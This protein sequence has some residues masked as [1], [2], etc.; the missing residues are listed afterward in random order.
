MTLEFVANEDL[1]VEFTNSAGPPDIVYPSDIGIADPGITAINST[2][3]KAGG[4]WICKTSL[5]MLFAVAGSPCP[6]TSATHVFI[7]G[8]G[9]LVA[10]AAKVLVDS[11]PPLRDGDTGTCAGTWQPPGGPP[12]PPIVC[13]CT[14]VIAVAGQDKV[15]AQ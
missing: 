6:H 7:A 3:S 2:T 4:K 11:M 12:P 9:A 8:G 15:K 10:T 5:T 14:T 1:E 13:A